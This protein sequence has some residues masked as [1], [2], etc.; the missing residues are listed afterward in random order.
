VIPALLVT[1]NATKQDAALQA[2]NRGDRKIIVTE[3]YRE[4]EELPADVH[5][6]PPHAPAKCAVLPM[7]AT[8]FAVFTEHAKQT[9]HCHMVGTELYT[10]VEGR[11][12]IE[13]EG[14]EYELSPGDVIIIRPGAF[15]EVRRAG[16]FLCHVITINC[17]GPQD[18][19]E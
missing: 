15:H 4:K 5:W 18:R 13:V 7:Q 16:K 12:T 17:G 14:A 6:Q 11:M 8:E 9:R 19:Y 3:V 2:G 10:L 1:L